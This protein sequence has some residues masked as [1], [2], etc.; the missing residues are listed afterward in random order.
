MLLKKIIKRIL[1]YALNV[2]GIE[3]IF[4]RKDNTQDMVLFDK[5]RLLFFYNA[6]KR[7]QLYY[8]ALERTDMVWSDNLFK[9][10]RFCN[11]LQIAERVLKNKS[12]EDFAE[13]GC[14]KGH[15]SHMISSL[16]AEYKL[17][18]RFHIFDSFDEGLS[19]K[20]PH[21]RNKRFNQSEKEI[22]IE[23]K[24]FSSTEACVQNA[25]ANFDFVKTYKGWI[26]DRFKDVKDRKFSF[27]HLDVD[28]YQPTLDSLEF[29]FPRLVKGGCLVVDDYGYTQ[30]PGA[31]TA[32]DNFLAQKDF[33]MFYE[34]PIGGCFIIK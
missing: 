15:S 14:W 1:Q 22:E 28:L 20:S 18:N 30:F 4:F 9:Q 25:L 12:K 23:K 27:V 7:L 11:M 10:L 31:T 33:E 2:F 13:C 26:P 5:N 32:V 24:I 19:D 16:I 17:N 21:D 8:E 29:F 3:A 34:N 6:N